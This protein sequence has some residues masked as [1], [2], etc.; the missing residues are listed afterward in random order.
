[1]AKKTFILKDLLPDQDYAV[2][3]RAHS[4]DNGSP[5]SPIFNFTTVRDDVAPNAP[6][7]LT[8][9]IKDQSFFLA[10]TEPTMNEDGTVTSDLMDYEVTVYPTGNAA[11]AIRE[12]TNSTAYEFGYFKNKFYF[13][14]AQADLTFEV[15]SRDVGFNVSQAPATVAATADALAAFTIT[16]TGKVRAVE[17]VW[18][19]Q[20]AA[21]HYN[22][23]R[24]STSGFTPDATTFVGSI[25]GVEDGANIVYFDIPGDTST[26]YYKVVGVSH[27]GTTLVS[28]EASAGANFDAQPPGPVSQPAA[29]TVA[30]GVHS[31]TVSHGLKK[32]DGVTALEDDLA[33]FEVYAATS[34]TV[35][36]TSSPASPHFVGR[37]PAQV[38][39]GTAETTFVYVVSADNTAVDVQVAA[40]NNAGDAS[41]ASA[42]ATS[43][44][45][46]QF[47]DGSTYIKDATI[48]NAHIVD[49]AANKLKANTAI[50]NSLNIEA[51]LT[52]NASGY[53]QSTNW[54]ATN[55]TGW[56]IG[57]DANGLGVIE[58]YAG[59]FNGTIE[60][61]AGFLDS[62]Y[63]KNTV[64]VGQ[65]ATAG[66]LQ[67]SNFSQVGGSEAGW[68]MDNQG[69]FIGYNASL[70]GAIYADSGYLKAMSIQGRLTISGGDIYVANGT[71]SITI[72]STGLRMY[73]GSKNTID[74]NLSTGAGTFRGDLSGNNISG[75]AITGGT[76]EGTIIRTAASG[77]RIVI[78]QS[79]RDRVKFYNAAGALTT[80]MGVGWPDWPYVGSVSANASDFQIRM[81]SYNIFLES[82]GVLT[83]N[84]FEVAEL[85]KFL[86]RTN[87]ESASADTTY[88]FDVFDGFTS[89]HRFYVSGTGR[90]YAN[91]SGGSVMTLR[92]AGNDAFIVNSARNVTMYQHATVMGNL[93]VEG[94]FTNGNNTFVTT[95]NKDLYEFEPKAH[96]HGYYSAGDTIRAASGST[97]APGFAFSGD[98]NTGLYNAGQGKVFIVTDGNTC[99]AASG[100]SLFSPGGDNRTALG[101]SALRFT[102]VWAVDTTVNSSDSTDKSDVSDST[103]GLDF[104]L[105][106]KP[107]SWRWS[108]GKRPH[109]GFI[110]QDVGAELKRR[111]IDFAGYIDPSVGGEEGGL[112]LRYAEFIAPTVKAVQEIAER[113]VAIEA[114][115]DAAGI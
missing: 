35:L 108:W 110:A 3:V 75:A 94:T 62:L 98:T 31:L 101:S 21:A 65:G 14:T 104:I 64:T 71:K 28:N 90:I 38:S 23:H 112:G 73:D 50:V 100:Y 109:Y 80:T 95:A 17:I 106:L 18:A 96:T 20:A 74:L 29:A 56:R 97:T 7:D 89:L 13:G 43:S 79:E 59:L 67:S 37:L 42:V 83:N 76:I 10:W 33:Y 88:V 39:D 41:A 9:T 55:K 114:R 51:L 19:H 36:D 84:R 2:Q 25:S 107:K 115:L 70:R 34:G 11:A 6:S 24:S 47:A 46:V 54:N 103:L 4:D 61:T 40:C 58:A 69:N 77:S 49:L 113:V 85:G 53:L 48:G 60:A 86:A 32:A 27:Y 92:V 22:V 82:G 16:A 72:D 102:S 99:V 91:A 78:D 15:R 12:Y 87:I 81:G 45:N 52:V 57:T 105:S 66:I 5:W 30:G 63:V 26:Y 8:V 93:S 1:M 111:N 44:P 68:K